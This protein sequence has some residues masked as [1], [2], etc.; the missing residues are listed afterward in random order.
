MEAQASSSSCLVSGTGPFRTS[1]PQA[2]FRSFITSCF[3]TR[4]LEAGREVA[5]CLP[6][7]GRLAAALAATSGVCAPPRSLIEMEAITAQAYGLMAPPLHNH[8][9]SFL[10]PQVL[11]EAGFV[12]CEAPQPPVSTRTYGIIRTV[13]V[14]AAP[15]KRAYQTCQALGSGSRLA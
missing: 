8:A 13:R 11:I 14:L 6:L 15:R 9:P 10:G 2:V 3:R 12:G 7:V 5:C 4:A 1:V